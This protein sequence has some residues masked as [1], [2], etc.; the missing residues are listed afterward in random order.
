MAEGSPGSP[1]RVAL[2]EV[3]D[4]VIPGA[5]GVGCVSASRSRT[6]PAPAILFVHCGGFIPPGQCR[7]DRY[8]RDLTRSGALLRSRVDV[9]GCEVLDYLL[10]KANC[11]I[12]LCLASDT[13][14]TCDDAGCLRS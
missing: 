1:S 13:S 3:A 7:P 4:S 9:V 10:R 14:V 11:R 5:G 6:A 2:V 12:S 8:A